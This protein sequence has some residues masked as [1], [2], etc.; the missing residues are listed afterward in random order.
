[1]FG[2]IGDNPLGSEEEVV[3]CLAELY[4]SHANYEGRLGRFAVHVWLPA[5]ARRRSQQSALRC[6]L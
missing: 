5:M 2:T 1:M 4:S 3:D 6:P